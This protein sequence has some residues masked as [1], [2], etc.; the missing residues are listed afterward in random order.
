MTARESPNES[1]WCKTLNAGTGR[2][3][4][5]SQLTPVTGLIGWHDS[6]QHAE[7]LFR[8]LISAL[9]VVDVRF[10][11][12]AQPE[13]TETFARRPGRDHEVLLACPHSHA[14]RGQP[15]EPVLPYAARRAR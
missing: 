15:V 12:F 1:D 11:R 7:P 4:E 14:L 9:Q 13:R 8:L 10:Q 3:V 5:Q 6:Q 2:V